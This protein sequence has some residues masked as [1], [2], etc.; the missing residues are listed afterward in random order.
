MVGELRSWT[1]PEGAVTH[2]SHDARGNVVG[3]RR[4]AKP[5]SGLPDIV[6]A[7]TYACGNPI[8][9]SKPATVTDANGNVTSWTYDSTH[10]GVL[11]Q[12][13]PAVGG[14]HPVV[15]YSYAQHYAWIKYGS[16]Y[17][18]AGAPVW[19]PA[20]TRTCRTS[21]TAGNACAAGASDEVVTTY[22]YQAG[23][24]STPSNLLLKGVAVTADGQ[25]LRTCY[26][27]DAHGRRISETAPNANLA[28]CP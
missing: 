19:L 8:T 14:V 3:T 2:L 5:G 28:S 10:G 18:T 23:N 7:A 11:T 6:T 12:T 27:H 1:D 20:T 9:C 24:S 22:E 25:T 26:G 13:M 15:R 16:A 17:I 4:V 21:A